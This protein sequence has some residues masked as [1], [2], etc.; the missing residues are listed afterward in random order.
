MNVYTLRRTQRINATLDQAWDFFS[1]PNNLNK[2]TPPEMAFRSQPVEL[3]IFAG[4]VI[5]HTVRVAPLVRVTWLT[6]LT[7]VEQGRMFIDEQRIGPYRFWHHRHVFT[8]CEGGVEMLDEVH[9][10][11]PF[12]P[13]GKIANALFVRRQLE[14][15]FNFREK[16]LLEMFG[17]AVLH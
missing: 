10:A 3:P 13:I 7:H 1:D 15:V 6:E 4:Q 11:L 16:V 9:Y 2:I 8:A 5:L 14:M 17:P 12:G